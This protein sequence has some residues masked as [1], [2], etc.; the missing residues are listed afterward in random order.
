MKSLVLSYAKLVKARPTNLQRL[1]RALG[2]DYDMNHVDL[3][4]TV[5]DYLQHE[6]IHNYNHKDGSYESFW[7]GDLIFDTNRYV[8]ET[9]SEKL[10]M[11]DQIDRIN[12]S[13]SAIDAEYEEA[14]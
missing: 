8:Q 3:A 14:K 2:I 11:V 13:A 7:E 6:D 1:A 5:A 4:A 9:F 10:S 12:Y